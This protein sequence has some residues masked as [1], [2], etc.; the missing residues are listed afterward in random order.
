MYLNVLLIR[1]F[2]LL[3]STSHIQHHNSD[4]SFLLSQS[5]IYYQQLLRCYICHSY[6][7]ITL[8][9]CL[10]CCIYFKRINYYCMGPA[11]CALNILERTDP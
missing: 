10:H 5:A 2:Y 11:D 6:S 3:Q 8:F 9:A 1:I 4:N 7:Y